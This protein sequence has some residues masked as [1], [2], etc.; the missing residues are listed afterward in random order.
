MAVRRGFIQKDVEEDNSWPLKDDLFDSFDSLTFPKF[1]SNGVPNWK[2]LR[3]F[4]KFQISNP[5]DE[6]S[7]AMEEFTFAEHAKWNCVSST[8]LETVNPFMSKIDRVK[9]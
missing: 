8:R 9:K 2:E 4:T 7:I 3:M 6:V 5:R 1:K